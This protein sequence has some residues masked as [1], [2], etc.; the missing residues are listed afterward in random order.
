MQC[1]SVTKHRVQLAVEYSRGKLRQGC[2]AV[3]FCGRFIIGKNAS[4]ALPDVCVHIFSNGYSSFGELCLNV[5]KTMVASELFLEVSPRPD[6]TTALSL[7]GRTVLTEIACQSV[8]PASCVTVQ[9]TQE[10]TD[11]IQP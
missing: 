4:V 6:A 3:L 2:P 10:S 11:Q 5:M 8:F 9:D 1:K 7:P